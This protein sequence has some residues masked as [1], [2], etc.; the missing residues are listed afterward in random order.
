M[1]NYRNVTS[2]S[3]RFDSIENQV[4]V[5]VEYND[6]TN[7]RFK[8]FPLVSD[9]ENVLNAYKYVRYLQDYYCCSVSLY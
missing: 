8:Y 3:V 9:P 7:G 4:V 2:V 6:L 5:W 1:D